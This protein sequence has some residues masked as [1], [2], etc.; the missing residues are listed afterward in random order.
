VDGERLIR[1]LE[2]EIAR[3]MGIIEASP[4]EPREE[5]NVAYNK[6]Y[7]DGLEYAI[8]EIRLLD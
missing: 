5:T 7:L 1:T 6:G 3:V 4:T 2:D 8:T